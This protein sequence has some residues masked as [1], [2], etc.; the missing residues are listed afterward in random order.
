M[1]SRALA[2]AIVLTTA[3]AASPALASDVTADRDWTRPAS[4]T[5]THRAPSAAQQPGEARSVVDE[6]TSPVCCHARGEAHRAV[7]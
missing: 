4:E 3:V 5:T 7:H 1:K 2:A 6:R